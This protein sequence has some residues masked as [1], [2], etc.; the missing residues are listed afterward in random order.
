MVDLEARDKSNVG[1]NVGYVEVYV[2]VSA[3]V[4]AWMSLIVHRYIAFMYI[5]CG[6]QVTKTRSYFAISK[7]EPTNLQ[8]PR[9]SFSWK[10]SFGSP[11][12]VVWRTRRFHNK[13]RK[14][15][16]AGSKATTRAPASA[17]WISGSPRFLVNG[18]VFLPR[19]KESENNSK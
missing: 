19:P 5:G 13:Y 9:P 4:F 16:G 11:K 18:W 6:K 1:R 17:F 15:G 14:L 7:S 3:H 2:Y 12:V 10:S 8:P